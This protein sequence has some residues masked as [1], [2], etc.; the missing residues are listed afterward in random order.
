MA[1]EP[2]RILHMMQCLSRVRIHGATVTLL[3]E[4]DHG[5]N[6]VVD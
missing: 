5:Y 6:G 4:H 2:G 1:C 3:G